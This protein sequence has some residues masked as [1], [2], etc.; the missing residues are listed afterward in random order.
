MRRPCE[1]QAICP[2]K[3]NR[4]ICLAK[5]SQGKRFLQGKRPAHPPL[6]EVGR[7]FA[8]EAPE[9]NNPYPLSGSMVPPAGRHGR[10]AVCESG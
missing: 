1:G 2:C 6:C 4:V 3:T 7:T 9:K 5:T 8:K 10:Q